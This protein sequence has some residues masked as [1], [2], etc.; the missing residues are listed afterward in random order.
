MLISTQLANTMQLH[1]VKMPGGARTQL[2]FFKEPVWDASY[3]PTDG[4][5]FIFAKDTGGDENYQKYRF[6]IEPAPCQRAK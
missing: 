6:D 4:R 5:Y 1:E 2:T 3:Q